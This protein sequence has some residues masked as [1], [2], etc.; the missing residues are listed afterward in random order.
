VGYRKSVAGEHGTGPVLQLGRHRQ[1]DGDTDYNLATNWSN[2]PAG[3]P[4]VT[5]G[6]GAI[7]DATGSTSINVT[8]AVTPYSWTFTATSQSY[9][10]SGSDINF[11]STPWGIFNLASSG[12]TISIS[13]NIGESP[14]G[15]QVM[16]LG[17]STLVFPA[18][19]PIP[20]GRPSR[21]AHCR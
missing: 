14:A 9:T 11:G 21:R 3:A 7:F 18:P 16:Q 1:Y 15:V 2:P 4:P 12:Q 17:A 13:N 20:A 19:T 8:S 6:Q 10:V 5:N